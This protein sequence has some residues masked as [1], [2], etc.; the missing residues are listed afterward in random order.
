MTMESKLPQSFL[1]GGLAVEV[2][3]KCIADFSVADYKDRKSAVLG[4]LFLRNLSDALV[5]VFDKT[6]PKD[7][8]DRGQ[9]EKTVK[10]KVFEHLTAEMLLM[11]GIVPVYA[12]VGVWHVPQS[13]IDFLL[14]DER[15]P[16]IFT[17]K[18]SLAERWRQAAYEGMCLKQVYRHA[19]CYV[20]CAD[21]DDVRRRNRNITDGEIGGVDKCHMVDSLDMQKLLVRLAKRKFS[22]AEKI[23]PIQ[24]K[25]KII[26]GVNL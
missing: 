5:E 11:H 4:A 1:G 21:K 12:Q 2:Y 6:K 26:E 15:A 19:E 9:W 25:P 3:G 24:G 17:C 14:F 20:I 13:K 10:G 22:F 8:S 16:V 23:D 18:M 7:R